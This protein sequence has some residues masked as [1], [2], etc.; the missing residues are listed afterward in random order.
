MKGGAV[1]CNKLQLLN[2]VFDKINPKESHDIKV[3]QNAKQPNK[4]ITS[5]DF[6]NFEPKAE[7]KK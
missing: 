4:D 1:N 3:D 6:A 2:F 5:F 7:E